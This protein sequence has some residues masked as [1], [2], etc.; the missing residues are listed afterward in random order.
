M[1]L[2]SLVA[3]GFGVGRLPVAPGTWGSL[4]ALPVAWLLVSAGGAPTLAAAAV[5][6]GLA[7]WW[8]SAAYLRTSAS[9]D[10]PGEVVI[11]EITGQWITL[12]FAPQSLA[13]YALAFALFRLFDIWKPWPVGWADRSLPGGLGVMVDDVLAGAY[14]GLGTAVVLWG[15][16]Q[17]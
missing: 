17:L 13:A 1:N 14:A 4:A 3:T 11:D 6:A 12:L 10:D 2:S 8:A 7:G 9:G 16:A 5:A 15:W